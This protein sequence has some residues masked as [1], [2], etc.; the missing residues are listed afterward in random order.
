MQSN[1]TIQKF[2]SVVVITRLGYT[3]NKCKLL[4]RANSNGNVTYIIDLSKIIS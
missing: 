2:G 3:K 1:K 4:N